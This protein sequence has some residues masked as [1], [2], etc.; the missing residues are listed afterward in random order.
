MER[1]LLPPACIWAALQSLATLVLPAVLISFPC[2]SRAD[3]SSTTSAQLILKVDP[4]SGTAKASGQN[5]SIGGHGHAG[6]PVLN[7]GAAP[8][9]GLALTPISAGAAFSLMMSV[10]P[11]DTLTTVSPTGSLPGYTDVSIQQPG[12]AGSLAGTVSSPRSG[13]ATAGG[14][15]TSATLTQS[16]TFSVF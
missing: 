16:T 11:A 4:A 7:N 15:G 8:A 1:I 10:K 6:T 14:A 5:Y 13:S 2:P 9:A 3:W 12:T